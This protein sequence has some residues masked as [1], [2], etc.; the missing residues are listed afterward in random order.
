MIKA[1]EQKLGFRLE[2]KKS[3]I[4]HIEAG[5]GVFLKTSDK[6]RQVNN[7]NIFSLPCGT[8]LGLVPGVIYNS[9]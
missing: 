9:Y 1:V 7:L 5:N 4:D 3:S 6:K 2:V 8:L